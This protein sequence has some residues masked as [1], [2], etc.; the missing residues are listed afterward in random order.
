[1][2]ADVFDEKQEKA[3][4]RADRRVRKTQ[5]ALSRALIELMVEKGY[6]AVTVQDIIDRADVG[7][8]T[9]Y[10]HF[11]DKQDLL[12][13]GIDE[14][15]ARLRQACASPASS[16]AL[17]GFSLEMFRHSD[18]HRPLIRALVGRKS[19]TLVLG[20]FSD[21]FADLVRQEL[22]RLPAS[23]QGMSVPH[24]VIVQFVVGAYVAVLTWWLES[25][26]D[27]TPE[28]M[29]RFFRELATPGVMLALGA[30][31]DEAHVHR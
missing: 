28:E 21:I 31:A 29:D 22:A 8:S 25:D 30:S 17:F 14:M 18:G 3:G 4:G 24:E 11:S 13:S 1:M 9:F 12:R 19:G 10:A 23:R 2:G 7:R 16:D 26:V 6:E 5:A 27:R 20:W 15:G